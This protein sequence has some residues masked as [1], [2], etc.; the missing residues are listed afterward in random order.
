MGV[1][2]VGVGSEILDQVDDDDD[3]DDGL[4]RTKKERS[5]EAPRPLEP[6]LGDQFNVR[7]K[8]V[9]LAAV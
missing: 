9:F 5:A 2:V 3:D 8:A 4:Q 6:A 7:R 1:G